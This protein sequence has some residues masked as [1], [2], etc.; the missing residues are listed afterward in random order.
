VRV[1][2][3]VHQLGGLLGTGVLGANVYLL[4]DDGLTLVDTG[5][6]GRYRSILKKVKRLGF[7]P[8]DISDIIITHHHADHVGSLARLKELTG[9]RVI[10][11]PGDAPYIDGRLPLLGGI[12]VLHAPGHTPGSICLYLKQEKVVIVGDVLVNRFRLGLPSRLF[13]VDI[14]QAIQ[15]IKRLAGLDFEIMCF[16]HG[17]PLVSGGPRAVSEFAGKVERK[18]CRTP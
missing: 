4:L 17:A 14:P 16:G 9:A 12:E 7:S 2:E 10:A 18:Y 13:T 3:H 15:S 8:S 1:T 6:K 5:L 11:H